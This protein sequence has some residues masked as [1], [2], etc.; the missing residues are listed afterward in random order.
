MAAHTISIIMPT[1]NEEAI[2]AASLERLLAITEGIDGVDI[3]V[4]DASDDATPGIVS[5][6]PVTLCRCKKGRAS[7]MNLGA[8]QASGDLLYFLHADTVPP[9]GFVHE[10]REAVA[11]GKE[12][13]CFRMR[14]DDD[15]P[16]MA[17]FG[18]CTQFPLMICRGGDQSLFVWKELF[19]RLGG[20]NESMVVMEEYD[21]ISRIGQVVPFHIL[22]AE[23]VTSARKYHRNGII[24]LQMHFGMVHLLYA[25]GADQDQL[26]GYC[27]EHIR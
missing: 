14:F 10:L 7:Q 13:G 6:F 24:P 11:A 8:W 2:I 25:M 4:C 9:P 23:V 21:L 12:A 16:L 19:F 15:H 3:V 22:E 20:Y 5:G 18:W 26:I 17:F 27:R 1:C